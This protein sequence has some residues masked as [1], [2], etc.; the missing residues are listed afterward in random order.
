MKVKIAITFVAVCMLFAAVGCH[1]SL[2]NGKTVLPEDIVGTWKAQE[3]PWMISLKA[4]GTVNS[5]LIPLGQVV[6]KPNEITTIQGKA[7]EPGVFDAG[8]F[9]VDYNPTNNSLSVT[10]DIKTVHLDMGDILEG[11][12]K[13]V[14]VGDFSEDRKNWNADVFTIMDLAMLVRDPNSPDDDPKYNKTT[15]F[16]AKA[17]DGASQLV[18]DK[19]EDVPN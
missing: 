10:I 19:V 14:L 12:C 16:S 8:N 15:T 6:V 3:S 13:Y 17:E 9:E 4:D 7:S 18:F 2:E 5:A 11:P 1:K